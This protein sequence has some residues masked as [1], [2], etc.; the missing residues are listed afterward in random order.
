[1]QGMLRVKYTIQSLQYY[2]PI[3]SNVAPSFERDPP[4]CSQVKNSHGLELLVAQQIQSGSHYPV[5]LGQQ[6][7]HAEET[8]EPRSHLRMPG[9]PDCTLPGRSASKLRPRRVRQDLARARLN[10]V[11]Y[12]RQTCYMHYFDVSSFEV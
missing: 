9:Q 11:L 6:A 10:C 12:S 2:S 7:F 1:M 3:G 5:A 4:N 8:L